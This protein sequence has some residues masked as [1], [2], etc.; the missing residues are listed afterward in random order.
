MTQTARITGK[1]EYREGDGATITIRPGPC[2]VVETELDVTISWIDGDSHGSAAM[3]I[4][5]Y[6]RYVASHAI[7]V[8]GTKAG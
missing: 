5:D 3:P 4:A 2:E 6:R 8:D 7:Q 1:V